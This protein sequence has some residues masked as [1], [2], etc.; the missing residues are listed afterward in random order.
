LTEATKFTVGTWNIFE[1]LGLPDACE[2]LLKA[3]LAV[4]ISSIVKRRGWSRSRAAV[5]LGIEKSDF[6][7]ILSGRL[8]PFS[9]NQMLEFVLGLNHDV[10]ISIRPSGRNERG[11]I[12]FEP[13]DSQADA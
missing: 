3:S 1:D 6:L 2:M 13:A 5:E 11:Q 9:I 4:Q 12:I 7:D 8:R 10:V